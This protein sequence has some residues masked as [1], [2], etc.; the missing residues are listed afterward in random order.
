[1]NK[2][3]RYCKE[4]KTLN[5]FNKSSIHKDGY[6]ARCRKCAN[7]KLAKFRASRTEQQRKVIW[8]NEYSIRKDK[9][10]EYFQNRKDGNHYIYLLPKENYVGCTDSPKT[11]FTGHKSLG[12]DISNARILFGSPDRELAL[13]LEEFLHDLGYEG[14]HERNMYR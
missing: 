1:M 3:C 5:D 11:R 7:E 10:K 14:R 4:T 9:V 12:R 2:Y 8:K 6:N 13:E